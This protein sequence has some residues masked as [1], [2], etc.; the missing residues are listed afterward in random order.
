LIVA[1][2]KVSAEDRE[3]L[4]EAWDEGQRAVYFDMESGDNTPNPYRVALSVEAPVETPRQA[5]SGGLY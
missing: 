5:D 2:Y 1:E 3:A 4:A